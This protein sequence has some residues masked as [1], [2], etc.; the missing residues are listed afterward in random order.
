MRSLIGTTAGVLLAQQTASNLHA[1]IGDRV[2]VELDETGAPAAGRLPAH[3]RVSAIVAGIVDLPFA[4]SFFQSVGEAHGQ[5]A[6]APPDNVLIVPAQLFQR[7]FAV[8]AIRRPLS[9][10]TQLHVRLAPDLPHDPLAALTFVVDAANHVELKS[11]GAAIVADNLAAQLA[12]TREDALYAS[13]LFLFLGLP[14]AALA[15][16]IAQVVVASGKDQWRR[17]AALL[18]IRGATT[19][20]ISLLAGVEAAVVWLFAA[21]IA[22][23]VTALAQRFLTPGSAADGSAAIVWACIGLAAAAPIVAAGHLIPVITATT[24][25]GLKTIGRPAVPLWRRVYLDL[26]L[27]AVGGAFIAYTAASG[28]QVVLAPEGIL[29]SSVSYDAFVG[30]L[31][32]WLGGG[33]LVRRIGEMWLA[34]RPL[35]VGSYRL[36]AGGLAGIVAA[37]ISRQRSDVG[38]GLTI[39]AL[40]I[41]FAVSTALFNETFNAQARVDAEL[42]NGAD[43]A[44]VLPNNAA[45]DETARKLAELPGAGGMD[46]MQHR[47]AYVG[48]DLQDLYGI[49][50]STI[51]KATDMSDAFFG[52]HNARATLSRLAAQSNGALLSEETIRDFQLKEGDRIALRLQ[53]GKDGKYRPVTFTF[54]GAIREFPTAPHD[55]FIVANSAYVDRATGFNVSRVILLRA[56]AQDPSAL[57]A[58]TRAAVDGLAG[59]RV[60][61]IAT[62]RKNVST[63]LT[64][65]DLHG[66]TGIEL[67]FALI[68]L[69]GASGLSLALGFTE[70]RRNFAILVALGATPAQVG[71]FLWAEAGTIVAGGL[72]GGAFL[73]VAVA[74]VLV[75]VLT[76][77]FD[78]PPS[79][80][81]VPW[82]YLSGL[83]ALAV[84]ATTIVVMWNRSAANHGFIE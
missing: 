64:S 3:R 41:A 33:L 82:P 57:A 78:P 8:Q 52:D 27:L 42:T 12:G 69:V 53:S 40:A 83:A 77:V 2:N 5:A 84:A 49:N 48:Q 61:D 43:V 65:V 11:A 76:G 26:I 67:A 6:Q 24:A 19:A 13:L 62:A 37:A 46:A 50:P 71:S 21:L 58:A 66:L 63:S 55:S 14:G 17:D 54:V 30:P 7:W 39:V 44:V 45:G 16:I 68:L 22:A 38:R 36:F 23:I 9:V 34:N 20:S 4:D 56:G 35:L 59:A 73:G 47:F 81:A 79:V 72:I 32:L 74:A 28:F 10:R 80:L 60:S 51:G 18:R 25:A 70:R 29:Q 15:A 1:R 75:K 31:L